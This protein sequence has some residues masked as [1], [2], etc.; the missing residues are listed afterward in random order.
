MPAA[1]TPRE[2]VLRA[3][4]HE[5]VDRVPTF[6][7]AE[8]SII[9]K[10]CNHFQVRDKIC[11]SA[12]LDV[13]AVRPRVRYRPRAA[14]LEPGLDIDVFGVKSKTVR[15]AS[16]VSEQVVGHVFSE[17]ST[18]EEIEAYAWPGRDAVDL[19]ASEHEAAR[20]RATG[21]AVYGGVWASL[22]TESREMMGEE[23]FLVSLIA[24]PDLAERLVARLADAYLEMNEAYLDRC[25]HCLDVFYMGSDLGTQN[26]LFISREMFQRFFAPHFARIAAQAK[27][28]G[29][30][31][32]MH[33]CG[34]VGEIIPD[35]IACGVDV[36]DP[37][38][39]S[40]AGM[41]PAS[42]ARAFKGKIAFHGAISTQ[43]TLPCKTPEAIRAEV[44]ETIETLGPLGLIAAPDQNMTDE[45]PLENIF[46]MYRAIREY[47]MP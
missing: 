6:F 32:M 27:R 26:S 4:R 37:V 16:L 8:P 15:Y 22:F 39:V 13:D 24:N 40:A 43:K 23:D 1:L 14:P 46:A 45:T 38:Q 7:R 10:L 25:R 3:I 41:D 30:P 35:L 36:L 11:I 20:A 12:A 19:D 5:E 33:T 29:L 9:Q 21:R 34:A 18:I 28:R 44:F 42:L 31:V 17:A 47:R 2:R